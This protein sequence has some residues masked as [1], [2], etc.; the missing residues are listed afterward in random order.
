MLKSIF[1]TGL[2]GCSV[3]ANAA[4]GEMGGYV[5]MSKSQ[6][7][8]GEEDLFTYQ[9]EVRRRIGVDHGADSVMVNIYK[10]EGKPK[11]IHA[12]PLDL[13]GIKGYIR[14]IA[15]LGVNG[16]RMAISFDIEMKAMDG[17]VLKE[18]MLVG[19]DGRVKTVVE[20]KG[21]DLYQDLWQ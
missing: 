15:F 11:L 12:I 16:D 6:S 8:V 2:I 9:V 3:L 20:A 13:P 10:G 7:L 18:V 4:G 19:K 17:L 1:F 21:V 5:W 14:D